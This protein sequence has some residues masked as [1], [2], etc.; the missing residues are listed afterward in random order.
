MS[1]RYFRS[2]IARRSALSFLNVKIQNDEAEIKHPNLRP[3]QHVGARCIHLRAPYFLDAARRSS[4]RRRNP[5]WQHDNR[6]NYR[7]A[8][9]LIKCHG[10]EHEDNRENRQRD[11][12]N[13]FADKVI[14]DV[15]RD[16]IAA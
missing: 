12:E 8:D 5:E 14:F 15:V 16:E 9:P 10:A 2:K 13:H 3:M 6:S 11:T 4:K 1:C 7:N